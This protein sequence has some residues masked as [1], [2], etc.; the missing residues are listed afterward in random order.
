MVPR[1]RCT[2]TRTRR[3]LSQI[4]STD[5]LG[6]HGLH[7]DAHGIDGARRTGRVKGSAP[8]RCDRAHARGREMV[9]G[10]DV[11]EESLEIISS[12]C[13]VEVSHVERHMLCP[14]EMRPPPCLLP[15][16]Q[17]EAR[18]RSPPGAHSR[19]VVQTL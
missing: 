3:P 7:E 1:V 17:E 4:S 8:S 11:A 16:I 14:D 5:E 15:L 12:S 18:E 13:F 10:Q 9:R 6:L 19:Q 2:V